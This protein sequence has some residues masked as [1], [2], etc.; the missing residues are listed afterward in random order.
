VCQSGPGVVKRVTGGSFAET[1]GSFGP[2]HRHTPGRPATRPAPMRLLLVVAVVVLACG[3][4]A[5]LGLQVSPWAG[6][7]LVALVLAL[8][9]TG[10]V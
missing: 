2:G 3:G 6:A 8:L 10:L 4:F 7:G 9:L 1:G 5:P